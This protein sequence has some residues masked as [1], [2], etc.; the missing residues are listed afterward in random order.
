MYMFNNEKK[1]HQ[2]IFMFAVII[3]YHVCLKCSWQNLHYLNSVQ[4]LHKIISVR[5]RLN[6]QIIPFLRMTFT[7]PSWLNACVCYFQKNA[8]V[9]FDLFWSLAMHC[10]SSLSLM[11]TNIWPSVLYKLTY[12]KHQKSFL[13]EIILLLVPYRAPSLSHWAINGHEF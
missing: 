11:L 10:I 1:W 7:F 8:L 2:T 12:S 5:L 4:W 9:M 3:L 13:W 6:V